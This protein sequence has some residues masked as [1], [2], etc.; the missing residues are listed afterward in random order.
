MSE[1]CH[2]NLLL[3]G[4]VLRPHGLGGFLKVSSFAESANSFLVAGKVYLRTPSGDFHE[5]EILSIQPLKGIF[6]MK[7]KGLNSIEEA[8]I[9]RGAALFAR[10]E[11]FTRESEEEYFWHEIIGLE[12]YLDTGKYIGEI[13]Q[14]L[15]T[16]SHDVYVVQ[17]GQSEVFIPAV[18]DVVRDIDLREGRM[19]ISCVEGL[20]DLNEA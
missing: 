17:G 3:L 10:K 19:I 18:R 13:R 20:L 5:E 11:A 12:V 1:E 14:I 4:R 7:L 2:D 6:L 16:G 15:P 9:Y 8:E